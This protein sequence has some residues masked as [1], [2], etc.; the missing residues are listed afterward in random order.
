M[1]PPPGL[2]HQGDEPCARDAMTVLATQLLQVFHVRRVP[3]CAGA[4]PDKRRVLPYKGDHG[5]IIGG[6]GTCRASELHDV[7]AGGQTH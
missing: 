6:K 2:H 3:G 7:Q 1:P 4:R 5:N